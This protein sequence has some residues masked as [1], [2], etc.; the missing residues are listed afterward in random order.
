MRMLIALIFVA[1]SVACSAAEPAAES[2]NVL[3]KDDGH[4]WCAYAD[5]AEFKADATTFKPTNSARITYQAN[6]LTELTY[7]TQAE[8][9]DW[10]VI[11][12]Y[13]PSNGD[14]L[15]RRANLIVQVNLQVIQE[16]VIHEG[17]VGVFR[18][19]SV[20]TLDGKK[21]ELSNADLPDVPA[22]TDLTRQPFVRVVAEMRSRAVAKLCK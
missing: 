14:L 3:L 12:K 11:D 15:L 5:P 13:T 4:T 2:F 18:T 8:S 19:V 22:K 9:G 16:S 7:Q 6:T 20:T 1:G 17:K 10:I 21:A